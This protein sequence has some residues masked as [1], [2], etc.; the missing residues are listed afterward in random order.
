M[1]HHLHQRRSGLPALLKPTLQQL[2]ILCLLPALL[3]TGC[4]SD[5]ATTSRPTSQEVTLKGQ[6]FT[7][8]LALTQEA[9]TR[10]LSYRESIPADGG[11]LFVFPEPGNRNFHMINC[12]VPID[13]IFVTE[14]GVVTAVH[15]MKV[16]PED[17][18][19]DASQI[20]K[21]SSR[22]RIM[23]V[24]ELQGGKA[25]EL[26]IKAGDRL[27]LPVDRLKRL[28]ESADEP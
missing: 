14:A 16:E 23:F 20:P 28:A 8:E 19:G 6:T 25:A 17:R 7:L 22:G 2:V 10:G 26:G 13:A 5:E 12:L 15:A 9:I 21:Y 27:E 3:V 24:I 1:R 18:R 11:M 4:R